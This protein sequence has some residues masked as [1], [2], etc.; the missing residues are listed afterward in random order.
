[1]FK[2]YIG[3]LT[4]SQKTDIEVAIDCILNPI[5]DLE[6]NQKL[7]ENKKVE[8]KYNKLVSATIRFI[9][10]IYTYRIDDIKFSAQELKKAIANYGYDAGKIDK[11]V[12]NGIN[13]MKFKRNIDIT[14]DYIE[15]IY[16]PKEKEK[17]VLE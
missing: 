17:V 11:R 12:S 8:L 15:G 10:S 7:M 3:E 13:N 9:D 14:V 2:F 6:R 5:F 4:E 1:M 16:S